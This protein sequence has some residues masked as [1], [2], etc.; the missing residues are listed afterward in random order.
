MVECGLQL[1]VRSS[2]PAFKSI[3]AGYR[4]TNCL[5]GW[6]SL[7]VPLSPYI[8]TCKIT[9]AISAPPSKNATICRRVEKIWDVISGLGFV[10]VQ[11]LRGATVVLRDT[12]IN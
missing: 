5:I 12:E 6:L 7:V 1:L 2:P 4:S 10:F 9:P 8:S 3:N 11:L